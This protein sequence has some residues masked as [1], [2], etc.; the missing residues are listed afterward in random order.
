[1][2]SRLARAEYRTC[3]LLGC[4]PDGMSEYKFY[5]FYGGYEKAEDQ[6]GR[7]SFRESLDQWCTNDPIALRE[8][9]T[10]DIDRV[11]DD[12]RA[13]TAESI[14]E[15]LRSGHTVVLMDSGGEQRTRQIWD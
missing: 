14:A 13:A 2:A 9:P 1:M 11:P 6:K 7:K 12:A 10:R 4:K 5:S 3:T 8:H 15:L